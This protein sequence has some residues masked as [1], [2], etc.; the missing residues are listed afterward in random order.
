LLPVTPDTRD[1]RSLTIIL[2]RRQPIARAAA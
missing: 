1:T 2:A